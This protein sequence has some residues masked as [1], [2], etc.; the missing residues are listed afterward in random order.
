MVWSQTFGLSAAFCTPFLWDIHHLMYD[1]TTLDYRDP[2]FHCYHCY[3]VTQPPSSFLLSTLLPPLPFPPSTLSLPHLA[4]L[5][6]PF[7]SLPLLLLFF[8]PPLI[9]D[10]TCK[11]HT[12]EGGACRS[13]YNTQVRIKMK[14]ANVS[15]RLPLHSVALSATYQGKHK[16][17]LWGS[18]RRQ[19]ASNC[20]MFASR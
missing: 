5:F 13:N 3:H 17:S 1:V 20:Y 19:V 16:T 7:P 9:I 11:G 4:S 15:F 6:P 14:H 18:W 2:L 8:L 10:P 12:S